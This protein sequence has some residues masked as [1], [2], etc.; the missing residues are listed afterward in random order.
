MGGKGEGRQK[1]GEREGR[2]GKEGVERRGEE[3]EG[4]GL[5]SPPPTEKSWIQL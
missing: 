1:K 3:R 5:H 2:R 4:R